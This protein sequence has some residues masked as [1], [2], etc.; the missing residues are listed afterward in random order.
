M[1]E[2]VKMYSKDQVNEE[3]NLID[4][5]LVL[6][7]EKIEGVIN[8][9]Y[10]ATK[11][12]LAANEIMIN[13]WKLKMHHD[14]TTGNKINIGILCWGKKSTD[15]VTTCSDNRNYGKYKIWHSDNT[16]CKN[17]EEAIKLGE[18]LLK[19]KNQWEEI[20]QMN[21]RKKLKKSY[22]KLKNIILVHWNIDKPDDIAVVFNS[23]KLNIYRFT[24]QWEK[25]DAY[26]KVYELLVHELV[27]EI[28]DFKDISEF[29]KGNYTLN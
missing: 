17:E 26:K 21:I 20:K 28:Y 24:Q 2:E 12:Q 11:E 7:H 5:T 6:T 8:G 23:S 10:T 13:F 1:K 25:E 4:E 19:E 29:E 9:D 3:Y 14:R 22:T 18:Y 27:N 15:I 16:Y